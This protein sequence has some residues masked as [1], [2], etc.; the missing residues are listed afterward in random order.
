M[1]EKLAMLGMIGPIP[2]RCTNRP[3]NLTALEFLSLE[4]PTMANDRIAGRKSR[5]KQA[6]REQIIT[7]ARRIAEREGWPSVTIRRLSD[8]ISYSQPV[9]Y[10][11]FESRETILAAVAIEGFKEI[12][13]VLERARTRA[14]R[15]AAVESVAAAYLRF[16][17]ASPAM[18]EVMFSIGLSVPFGEMATPAELRFGFTQL[19]ELFKEQSDKPEIVAEL[20]WANLHGIAEL[21]RTGR[22]PRRLQKERLRALVVL[23]TAS[24]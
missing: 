20:F 2:K 14:K 12:G 13:L 17:E 7:A 11:H 8:E 5:E 23:F 19:L 15:G 6:R 16:A 1:L 9:L 18:Y 4:R 3:Y 10:S 21:T 22:F 24:R